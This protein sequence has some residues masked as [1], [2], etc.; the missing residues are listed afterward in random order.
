MLVM[1]MM[2][3]GM[4]HASDIPEI[5]VRWGDLAKQKAMDA[6]CLPTI[7][8]ETKKLKNKS[9]FSV[10]CLDSRKVAYVACEVPDDVLGEP[11]C[12]YQVRLHAA[13]METRSF[14]KNLRYVAARQLCL[15]K[16]IE[17]IKSGVNT[18]NE[19]W[20]L[21]RFYCAEDEHRKSRTASCHYSESRTS[22]GLLRD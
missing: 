1:I 14:I 22:C 3:L 6:G 20:A 19:P 16:H 10:K 5:K 4:S 13:G 15:P 17:E 21:Y 11:E 9:H 7:V 12:G 2:I 18:R 8:F